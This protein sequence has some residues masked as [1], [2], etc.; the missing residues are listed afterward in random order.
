MSLAIVELPEIGSAMPCC[1]SELSSEGALIKV[2]GLQSDGGN[3]QLGRLE[4]AL[5]GIQ[6]N[7]HQPLSGDQSERDPHSTIELVTRHLRDLG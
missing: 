2:D 3:R 5:G 6:T 7:L 1:S 4:H